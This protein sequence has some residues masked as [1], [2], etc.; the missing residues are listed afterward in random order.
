MEFYR[1]GLV[2]ILNFWYIVWRNVRQNPSRKTPCKKA[3][4]K[5]RKT[6]KMAK[7]SEIFPIRP[8]KTFFLSPQRLASRD[9]LDGHKTRGLKM[10]GRRP[11]MRFQSPFR[12]SCLQC[13]ASSKKREDV[14]KNSFED[15]FGSLVNWK[16]YFKIGKSNQANSKFLTSLWTPL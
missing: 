16:K 1:L 9:L 3:I 10:C 7:P 6:L 8:S 5:Q 14:K 12:G 15:F 13:R 4:T 11:L 2:N